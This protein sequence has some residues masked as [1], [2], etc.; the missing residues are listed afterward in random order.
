MRKWGI[1]LATIVC[2]G[3]G[4][5]TKAGENLEYGQ[6]SVSLDVK[7]IKKSYDF[8]IMLGFEKVMGDLSQKWIILTNK[9]SVIGLFE[10]ELDSNLLTFNP[11]DVRALHRT[12]KAKGIKFDKEPE[13]VSGPA[14][15]K[16]T[17]PDG[18]VILLDQH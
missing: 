8:Y 15:A 17:D 6:F 13:G 16:L 11:L 7:D 14:H 5:V 9:S 10:G 3:G 12:L 4:T 18:N 1:I 2:L